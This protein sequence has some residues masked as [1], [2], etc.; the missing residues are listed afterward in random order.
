MKQQVALLLKFPRRCPRFM[1]SKLHCPLSRVI[2]PIAPDDFGIECHVLS[3]I[4]D[5]ADFIQVFPDLGRMTRI[6]WPVWADLLLLHL[7]DTELGCSRT[8][9]RAKLKVYACEGTSH[10]HP[11]YRFSSHVP[12]MSSF[13]SY[14][15]CSTLLQIRKFKMLLLCIL[16]LEVISLL[17]LLLNLI[18]HH[19]SRNSSSNCQDLKSAVRW[20]TEGDVWDSVTTWLPI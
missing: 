10:A 6:P 12:P 13:F 18:R 17:T 1:L 9:L 16:A 5:F 14:I 8:Y 4:E 19:Y 3:K 15:T 20:I 11:G 7:L 2:I